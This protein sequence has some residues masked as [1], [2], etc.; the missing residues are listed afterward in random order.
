[1]QATLH[2]LTSHG[3]WVLFATVLAEQAGLPIPAIPV[4]LAMGA[5]AGLGKFSLPVCILLAVLAC[6]VSDSIWFQLGRRNGQSVLRLLC[7]IS[8]EP[9]SCVSLAKDWFKRM[10]ASALVL[11]KFVPGFST[12]A[13]PMAGVNRMPYAKF[14]FYDS[15]GSFLWAGVALGLGFLFHNQLE[16]VLEALNRLGSWLGAVVGTVLLAW[17]VWKWQQR[18]RFIR[19]LAESRITPQELYE[20]MQ[21][22]E[23]PAIVDLRREGELEEVGAKIPGAL[24]LQ[25][26]DLE[27]RHEEIP[28]DR[29]V[30]LYCS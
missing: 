6:L 11:A 1:M 25:L 26:G 19:S 4:L 21:S 18:R 10:G 5:L 29:F 28:R 30:V 7:R 8:L 27:T 9:D 22:G 20:L 24:W 16:A 2:F 13:P 23:S 12:A 17:I 3:Y 15:T 14:V